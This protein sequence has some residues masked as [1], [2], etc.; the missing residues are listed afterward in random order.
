MSLVRKTAIGNLVLWPK[1]ARVYAT[2]PFIPRTLLAGC[3][4]VFL[5]LTGILEEAFLVHHVAI[6]QSI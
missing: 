5:F 3:S 2:T 1:L 6:S 4:H